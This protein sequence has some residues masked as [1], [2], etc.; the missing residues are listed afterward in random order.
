MYCLAFIMG[1]ACIVRKWV[2][3]VWLVGSRM[4]RDVDSSSAQTRG[5]SNVFFSRP[6]GTNEHAQKRWTAWLGC[7]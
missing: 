3:G 6:A 1:F 7:I 2:G 5:E 4:W